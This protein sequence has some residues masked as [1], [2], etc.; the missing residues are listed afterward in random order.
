MD[1]DDWLINH[2]T[3]MRW[4]LGQSSMIWLHGFA[5]TGKTGLV[6]WVIHYLEES[7]QFADVTGYFFCSSDK[8]DT[9]NKEA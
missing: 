8:A 2:E 5:G 3:F 1:L 4:E 7:G 6:C 9:G